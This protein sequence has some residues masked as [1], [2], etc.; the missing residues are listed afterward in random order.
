MVKDK[1]PKAPRRTKTVIIEKKNKET[2]HVTR[3]T[4]AKVTDRLSEFLK[5]T[6]N[7]GSITTSDEFRGD[8]AIFRA[9]VTPDVKKPERYFTGTSMGKVGAEKALEKL[10]TLA[11]G[12]ALAF[13]GYLSTGEIASAEE[14]ERFGSENVIVDVSDAMKKLEGAK[15]LVELAK[16]YRSLTPE[17]RANKEVTTLKDELKKEFGGVVEEVKPT[18]QTPH[19]ESVQN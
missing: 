9:K 14:M 10:E 16:I 7:D 13:A 12:R 15:T 6:G 11:V 1:E 3:I 18:E 2:G 17:E 5:A 8:Y 19:D 4:Y